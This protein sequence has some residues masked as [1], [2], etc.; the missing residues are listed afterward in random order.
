M[1]AASVSAEPYAEPTKEVPSTPSSVS[2]RTRP[3]RV[4][5]LCELAIVRV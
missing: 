1:N 5:R 3:I 2:M 4:L